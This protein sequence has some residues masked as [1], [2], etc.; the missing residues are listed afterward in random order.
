MKRKSVA[1][2]MIAIVLTAPKITN[3]AHPL[4]SDDAGTQGKGKWQVEVLGEY[5]F[6]KKNSTDPTSI[7]TTARDKDAELKSAV[8]YGVMDSADLVFTVPYQWKRSDSG[9]H[10]SSAGGFSDFMLELKWRFFEKDGLGVALK[11]GL[12]FPTGDE[13][14]DLGTGRVGYSVFL[15]ATRESSPW[16]LNFNLGYKRNE[17]KID[18][19]LDIWH[20]SVSGEYK[21]MKNLKALAN[22]GAERNTDKESNT[23]PA[24]ALFGFIY[25]IS[26]ALDIDA[27]AKFGLN[28]PETDTALLAGATFRF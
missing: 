12:N 2:M 28:E 21:I 15:L 20:V 22:I 4:I 8:T 26:E 1:I 25:S 10:V 5:N 11:P 7:D 14:K 17:N 6:D 19:R 13:E 18:E 23:A 3:A 24:F 16:A 9:N 27:G